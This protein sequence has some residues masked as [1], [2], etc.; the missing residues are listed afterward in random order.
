[1]FVRDD[2][3][4]PLLERP[5]A[6]KNLG[7]FTP[8]GKNAKDNDLHHGR[9]NKRALATG[10]W[11]TLEAVLI[12]EGVAGAQAPGKA[13]FRDPPN[14]NNTTNTDAGGGNSTESS[15]TSAA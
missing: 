2:G 6:K 4:E 3:R 8:W 12:A 5:E 9:N 7:K 13:F 11:R 10:L 1:M 14:T 15:S